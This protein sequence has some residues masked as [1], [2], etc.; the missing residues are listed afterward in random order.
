MQSRPEPCYSRVMPNRSS[1]TPKPKAK[2]KTRKPPKDV[3][4]QAFSVVKELERRTSA[5]DAA[6]S[7]SNGHKKNAAA[8]A[9]GRLGGLKGGP[10]RKA[11][12]TPEER[13]A[14]A[15]KA[16]NARWAKKEQRPD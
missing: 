9:L 5:R 8:V 10:A 13:S 2:A 12:L 11:S 15:R 6:K 3:N 7:N 1:K 16:V 4:E 14:I